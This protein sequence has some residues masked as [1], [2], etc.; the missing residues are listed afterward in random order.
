MARR[1]KNQDEVQVQENKVPSLSYSAPSQAYS[2][3]ALNALASG[4]YKEF[5]KSGVAARQNEQAKQG[6]LDKKEWRANTDV[7]SLANARQYQQN[8]DDRQKSYEYDEQARKNNTLEKRDSWWNWEQSDQDYLQR[9]YDNFGEEGARRALQ[10]S[11]RTKDWEQKY[12]KSYDQI[13]NDFL[14]D[15]KN[16]TMQ[17]GESHPFLTEVG[18][19]LNS[20]PVSLAAVPS[21]ITNLVDP[22]NPTAQKYE[23]MRA[24]NSENQRLLREG[25]KKNT[26]DYGDK[27]IDML[28]S[29][30][31]RLVNTIAGD[32]VVKGGGAVMAGLSE[33]N[34]QMDDLALRPDMDGRKKALS[35]LGHGAI[36]GAGTAL[37]GG[38]LDKIPGAQNLKGLAGNLGKGAVEG[39]AENVASEVGHNWLDDLIYGDNSQA[40][41]NKQ[42]YMAQGMSE[43]EADKK[44]NQ[45]RIWQYVSSGLMGAGFGAGMRGAKEI[46]NVLG[47]NRVPA[48]DA[49]VDNA[50]E[51]AA[52]KA[53]EVPTVTTN[54]VEVPP[55]EAEIRAELNG[56]N[57]V[58]IGQNP[59]KPIILPGTQGVIELE[60][61]RNPGN[62]VA[63][64][65][66]D[67]VEPNYRIDTLGGADGKPR[68]YVKE[69]I[70]D[71]MSRNAEPGKVYMTKEEAQQ[72]LDRISKQNGSIV[73]ANETIDPSNSRIENTPIDNN[74]PADVP[75]EPP[76]KVPFVEEPNGGG[77]KTKTSETYTN[78]AKRGR[79]WT[80]E[81]Y[82]TKTNASQFQY[83]TKGEEESINEAAGMLSKEGFDNFKNRVMDKERLTGA[84]IDGL[85]MEWRILAKQARDIEASGQDAS[86]AWAESI[87]VFRKIQE[88][89]SSNAQALQA[90]AKW[91]RN[92]PEGMLSRAESILNGKTKVDESAA[93]KVLD[94]FA[95]GQKKGFKFSD[96]FV[97]DF[98]QKAQELDDLDPNS[99][100]YQEALA[101]LGR[102]VNSQLPSTLGEKVKTVLMDNML[103]NFRTLIARN[104]GGN[105]GLNAVEQF[106]QRPLAALIDTAVSKK[107]GRRTQAGLSK[108]GLAEYIN[109]FTKGLKDEAADFKTKLHTAR[110]GEASIEEAI[111][112]N[113]HVFKEG[114]V[115]DK[116]DN[117]VKTGLSIG[118]RPF[119]E[120]VYNQTL[121]DYARLRA[122]GQ[123]G[124]LVQSLD[125]AQFDEYAKTA[126][127]LNAL[128]AVYQQDS[129]LSNALLNFKESVGKLSE[130]IVGT[131]ILSQFSMPFVKTPANVVERA[132]D[133]SPL[134]FVRNAFR[135]GK[136][137]AAGAFDQNRFVNETS[138][139]ILGTGLMA[140]G[141]G[142]GA[143]G[144]MSGAYSDDPD[145]KKAQRESGM[146]E[147]A[148]NL[149]GNKQMDIGWIPVLGSNLVAADAAYEAY[150]NGEGDILSNAARGLEAGGQA[151]FDQSM[152]Q[153]LQRLFG[154]G[155]AYDTDTGIV[156]NMANVV[157]SGFGQAIP[158]LARQI[159]QVSDPYKRDL[160]YSNEGTSAGFMDNYDLNSLANNIPILR[161]MVLAPQ[162]NTSG[163]LEKENQ[164]RNV[165]SKVLED[166]ILPGK[167][168]Q[169]EY[170]ALNNEAKR[171]KDATT[172]A[173]AYMPKASR[174]YIDTDKH[175]LS[176]DE[177]SNYQ[178]N[179]YGDMT[180]AGNM[181]I[182]SDAYKNADDETKVQMLKNTYT[183]IRNAL[184]S[185]YTGKEQSGAAKKYLEAGGGEKGVKAVVDYYETKAKADS[186]GMQVSTYEKKEAEYDGGAVAYAQ[187]K[188]TAEDLGISTSTYDK[189]LEKAGQHSAEAEQALPVLAGMGLP[190]NALYTYANALQDYEDIDLNE[191]AQTYSEMN[192]DG[193]NGLK[194]KE[195]LDYINSFEYD[196]PSEAEDLWYMFGDF[197]NKKGERKKIKNVDGV[198]KSYY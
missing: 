70:G 105:L 91:S 168:S 155:E 133:Y 3:D 56:A 124:D 15:Q 53:D 159:A 55:T 31:D 21:L 59:D 187:N 69:D 119:Y 172:S 121:G 112:S 2:D 181:I 129:K 75:P 130:G 19:A 11:S 24:K 27:A 64:K 41:L 71:A 29:I 134:G 96:E 148:L 126:A 89:S 192:T 152:F 113:R 161:E 44:V 190:T 125:D 197:T 12:G 114:G 10:Q 102:M 92:T 26:G 132:I 117:L 16:I 57:R 32:A 147:Y 28:N 115:M 143:A 139:N 178:Q 182:N 1:R 194:E 106:A 146:Q 123:M 20:I 153:G 165:V 39:A 72:A 185:E 83:E 100:E 18:T 135:T 58:G 189:V 120:A 23:Q 118:D 177:W 163:E 94:K 17:M 95:K 80:E 97:K 90:L 103:G 68:Y 30:G 167:I 116:L 7:P 175:T 66:I 149:P 166:M 162:V 76:T 154:S 40:N 176:N 137:R 169:V 78:T 110:S 5:R 42:L 14:A 101:N 86:A 174:K 111:R 6:F 73:P 158:S 38:W 25:V 62:W 107:T 131:D 173:D 60:D 196:D 145:E 186:L 4:N 77:K 36:E 51:Q 63:Q 88:Q 156:G 180:T 128:A 140:G 160:A 84:E 33:A 13:L 74:S 191:F 45:D 195:I 171:L 193:S 170:S 151:L 67:N 183:A 37:V 65:R 138:R 54:N 22:G 48:L 104:A 136:E 108:E 150:K 99:R 8:L 81:E 142:L 87:R 179:Y 127:K 49:D 9:I 141:I 52:R 85:M 35:A 122:S 79:G 34:K 184:Q 46:G 43:E 82:K 164:G 109:G 157:K 93:Q 50:V 47:G 188:Q 144:G 61:T 98:L 198:W